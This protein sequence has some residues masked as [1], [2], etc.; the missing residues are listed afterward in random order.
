MLSNILNNN[1]ASA[2]GIKNEM[3]KS[4]LPFI[5]QT[6]VKVFNKLLKEGQFSVSSTEGIIVPVYKQ[7]SYTD[8]NNYRGI[9]SSSCVGTLFCHILNT[10]SSNHLENRYF[11]I[12]EQAGFLKNFGTFDQMFILKINIK[13]VDSIFKGMV[14]RISYMLAVLTVR[15]P[16]TLFGTKT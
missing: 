12:R 7:G 6:V 14:T 16:S 10:R 11:L 8:P 4:A 2:Y 9:T 13:I 1:K 3:L 5:K 15:R